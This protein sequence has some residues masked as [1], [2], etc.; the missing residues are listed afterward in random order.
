MCYKTVTSVTILMKTHEKTILYAQS[1]MK[2]NV[3]MK[4]SHYQAVTKVT[5][6]TRLR[7]DI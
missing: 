4:H 1:D 3:K 5:Q 6:L 7:A 2:I